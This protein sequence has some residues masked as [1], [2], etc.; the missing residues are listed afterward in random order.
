MMLLFFCLLFFFFKPGFVQSMATLGLCHLSRAARVFIFFCYYFLVVVQDGPEHTPVS[1]ST[2]VK[3]C[4]TQAFLSFVNCHIYIYPP[5][6][7]T[8]QT[9]GVGVL[10][11]L[12]HRKRADKNKSVGPVFKHLE[13]M[14]MSVADKS[15]YR[16]D[17]FK[18]DAPFFVAVVAV[19]QNSDFFLQVRF[20]IQ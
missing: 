16:D 19:T 6:P 10:E 18:A 11:V 1:D 7:P 4:E 14:L 13:H 3:G 9:E 5:P 2:C 17:L 12:R 15:L 8:W 20:E